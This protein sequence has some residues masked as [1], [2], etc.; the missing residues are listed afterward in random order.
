MKE[1]IN[2][3]KEFYKA[4]GFYFIKIDAEIEKLDKN[5]VNLVYLIDKGEKAKI[6]KIYFLGDKKIREKRLRDVIT[7]QENK[8]WKFISRSVYLNKGR[9]DLDKRLLENYS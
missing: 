4:Q 9:I 2:L 5:R 3:I 7:S 6:A 1:N 8:F